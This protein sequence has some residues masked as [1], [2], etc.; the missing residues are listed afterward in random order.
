M[1]KYTEFPSVYEFG[2]SDKDTGYFWV[3]NTHVVLCQQ[4]IDTRVLAEYVKANWVPVWH[5]TKT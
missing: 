2:D 5:F 3:L 4:N 1:E